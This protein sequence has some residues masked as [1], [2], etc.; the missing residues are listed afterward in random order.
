LKLQRK[1]L[2]LL[3]AASLLPMGA[4]AADAAHAEPAK[5]ETAATAVP[6]QREV[7]THGSVRIGNQDL[8]YTATAG[9]IILRDD[10]N[11][12]VATMF[13]VAYT[14]DGVRNEAKRPITFLYNGGP[15]SSSIWL[16]MGGLGPM[17][18]ALNNAG[19]TPPAPYAIVPNHDSLL[20]DSD[21]V[22]I[23]ASAPATATWSARAPTRCSGAWIRT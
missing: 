6:Q 21:L 10:K 23:D 3:L 12:P 9:T 17:K 5:T 18:V 7:V 15:G 4:H 1:V 19:A 14:K 16:H 8:R 13:Y 2:P 20:N 11:E 22:F